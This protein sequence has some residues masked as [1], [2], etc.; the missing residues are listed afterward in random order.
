MSASAGQR[1]TVFDIEREKRWR[2]WVLFAL[3][4]VMVF[5]SVWVLCLI[6]TVAFYVSFPVVDT[7]SWVFTLRGAG[8]ILGISG[9]AS[10][11]YW[12]AAQVG[13]R[14]R[15][16]RAMHCE[17]LDAGDRYHQRLANVVEEM[18]IATG[19]PRVECV[20][21]RTLGL[22]AFAFSDLHGGGVIGVTEGAL[23]RL[24]RQ[25]LQGVVAHEFAHVLSG[26][27]V[28]VTVSCLLFGIYSAL[29][30]TLE[31]T[32]MGAAGSRAA[33]VAAGAVGAR[34]WL[35]VV[36]R[37][38]AVL[39]ASLSRARE[40][41]ADVAAAL[42]TR[43][44]LSLAEALRIISRHPG[45]VGYIPEGLAPLCIRDTVEGGTHGWMGTH[46]PLGE[47]IDTL[48]ALAAASPEQFARQVDA[49]SDRFA[50]REHWAQAPAAGAA[51]R[52]IG[53][54]AAGQ[55]AAAAARSAHGDVA[56]AAPQ[57]AAAPAPPRQPSV[58]S[59]GSATA[60]LVPVPLGAGARAAGAA[61]QAPAVRAASCPS[62]GASLALAAYEGLRVTVCPACGGRLVTP[63][64]VAKILARREVAFTAE[65]LRLADL[66]AAGGDELRRAAAQSRGRPQVALLPCPRCGR[67]MVRRHF[68][69]E[70]AV[71]VDYC[72]ICD[73]YWFERDELEALQVLA[74]RQSG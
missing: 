63:D 74:E 7:V 46:P 22:N 28:T 21:V 35:W 42:Y 16:L 71:E 32:A 70:H 47:R 13:A 25:Q 51:G 73:L 57:A 17:P 34:A 36:Q 9:A 24:S 8:L 5:A 26:T 15:L 65:Q 59:G 29:G 60:P 3:L 18:R 45:G 55:A 67:A 33:P 58:S 23:A 12:F 68:N 43:D 6:V 38:S 53:L 44:P 20:T 31:D 4:L 39:S 52:H 49:A 41:Q 54:A 10:L 37:A 14:E 30:D 11:L 56:A 19:A 50:A 62:C 72:S 27:Y 64:E 1:R 61:A 48:L 69:Y 66:L 2:I 40:R